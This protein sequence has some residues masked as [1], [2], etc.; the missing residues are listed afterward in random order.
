MAFQDLDAFKA[1]LGN[2][3]L[4]LT[5][6]WIVI[7]GEEKFK[8]QY[9]VLGKN[10]GH[11]AIEEHGKEKRRQDKEEQIKAYMELQKKKL[12]M[13]AEIQERTLEMEA[14]LYSKKLK[15]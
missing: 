1:Q 6:C 3:S 13:V 2:K 4:N 9:A 11:Q 5:H 15:M 7:K 12:E 8:E 10:G 14:E